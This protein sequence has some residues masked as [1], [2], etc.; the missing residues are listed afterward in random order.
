LKLITA[1]I[2]LFSLA[3]TVA[4]SAQTYTALASFDGTNGRVPQGQLVQGRDG[5]FYGTTIEEK[6][7]PDP[8]LTAMLTAAPY[9]KSLPAAKSLPSTIF[10]PKPAAQ[11]EIPPRRA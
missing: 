10:A 6:A 2:L 11:T 3:T 1:S 8:V 5:N 7:E 9:S 4:L